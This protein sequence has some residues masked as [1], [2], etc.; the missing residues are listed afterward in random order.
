MEDIQLRIAAIPNT[1]YK[2]YHHTPANCFLISRRRC[3]HEL[4]R[5]FDK[6]CP[7]WQQSEHDLARK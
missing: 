7:T 5:G 1:S 2:L 4:E 3:M 6:P